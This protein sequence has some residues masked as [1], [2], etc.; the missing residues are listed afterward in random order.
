M[1]R[2]VKLTNLAKPLW[3]A[4]LFTKGDL[5][6]YYRAVAPALLPHLAGRALTL[7][8]YPDGVDGPGWFQSNCPPGKPDWLP[9]AELPA[10]TPS[11][12][13][14]RSAQRGVEGRTIRYCLCDD[15]PSLLWI[16]NTGA[17]ELHPFLALARAPGRPTA[18][19]LDL[20]PAPP[21]GLVAAA[22][23]A[24]V[25][26]DALAE[27]AGLAAFPKPSGMSGLHLF[28]PLGAD[29]TFEGSKALA[30][31]RARD[32]GARYPALF[33][34]RPRRAERAG[35]VY[36]DWRQFAAGLSTVAPYSVR[37]TCSRGW[38][39]AGTSSRACFRG[40]RDSAA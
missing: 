21:A 39:R 33:T 19:V 13:P 34:D 16:A 2:E 7:A 20:D 36:L 1:T 3:P 29:A 24:L 25:A 10:R 6:A 22:R 15:L 38:P 31:A 11:V 4:P 9:V 37:P 32:L 26:R 8:R 40:P 5:V 30:R 35:R 23:A 27:A 18:L 12:R 14:E 17:I 28:A